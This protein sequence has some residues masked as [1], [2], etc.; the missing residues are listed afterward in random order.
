MI[1][2]NENNEIL[3]KEIL[4]CINNIIIMCN[5]NE[6]LILMCININVMCNMCVM[7]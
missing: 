2:I 3:M 6:I 7:Y 1:M 5:I 4:I